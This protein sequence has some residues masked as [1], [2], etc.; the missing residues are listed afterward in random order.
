MTQIRKCRAVSRGDVDVRGTGGS[1]RLA[2]LRRS[3]GRAIRNSRNPPAH[4]W[5]LCAAGPNR[6]VIGANSESPICVRPVAVASRC[7]A[8]CMLPAQP[9]RSPGRR[10]R[11][12]RRPCADLDHGGV[13][14]LRA[15]K[16]PE[17]CW[18]ETRAG[19][20]RHT[21]GSGSKTPPFRLLRLARLA[22]GGSGIDTTLSRSARAA[23]GS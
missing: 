4:D 15:G 10:L 6:S 1:P 7:C 14:D 5:V 2:T 17:R 3:K 18:M 16:L 9:R 12:G 21:F 8:R 23:R 13:H 19:V 20:T 11:S 22:P